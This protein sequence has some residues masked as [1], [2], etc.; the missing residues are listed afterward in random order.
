MAPDIPYELKR[1]IYDFVDLET[2]KSLRQVSKAWASVGTELL[3][4]PSFFVKSHSVD[5]HRLLD[6]GSS[7]AVSYQAAKTIKKVIF[8]NS[9]WNPKY[10]R[11]IV[12]SRHEHRRHY[13]AIDFVPTRAEA[14]ALA[15]LD[16]VM[17]Q[18]YKDNADEQDK[19][20]LDSFFRVVPQVN[21]IEIQSRNP[22]QNAILRKVW[23]EYSLEAHLS[24]KNQVQAVLSAARIAGL[25]IQHFSHDQLLSSSF[26]DDDLTGDSTLYDDINGLKSLQLVISDHKSVFSTDTRASLRLRRLLETIS[27]LE[28]LSLVFQI[29]EAIPLDYLPTAATGTL[30]SLT[31]S[32][33][34]VDPV[35]FLALLEGNASKL[36]RLRLRSADIPQGHGT[37]RMLLDDLRNL[38]GDKLEKFQ[39]SGMVRS[40]D[41]DGEQWYLPALYDEKWNVLQGP[42]MPKSPRTKEIEDFVLRGGPWPMVAA[43]TFL[44]Q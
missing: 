28:D 23:E 29:L 17:V 22:F 6:I 31:L 20:L 37:W 43:D 39:I 5:T 15:E 38:F 44:F 21:S 30:R 26:E 40:V 34:S 1:L 3:L 8:Q 24:R 41:G 7:P 9:G 2:I 14:A 10:F 27:A 19:S 33:I 13:A 4:L 18:K 42:M 25:K 12:C 11:R 36:K 35:Q 32:S 16:E